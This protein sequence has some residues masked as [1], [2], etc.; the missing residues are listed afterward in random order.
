[1]HVVDNTEFDF[2]VEFVTERLELTQLERGSVLRFVFTRKN[3]GVYGVAGTVADGS[4]AGGSITFLH[5]LDLRRNQLRQY[6][7]MEVSLPVKVRLVKTLAAE[8]SMVQIGEV[9]ESK[10]VD[11]SGGGLS[12]LGEKSLRPGDLVS[13]HFSLPHGMFGGCGAKVV[14]ISLQEGKSITYY[15]HHVQFTNLETSKREQ[16]VRYIFEK[17]RQINQW[18]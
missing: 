13:L 5:T 8:S 3:D 18:R 10:M 16:I 9:L 14:R 11:L 15:R 4:F 6:V 1:V 12:F 2:T 17:Q 7:R